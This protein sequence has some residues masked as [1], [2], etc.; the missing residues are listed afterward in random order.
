LGE[1]TNRTE[2]P[3]K[4]K[5]EEMKTLEEIYEAMDHPKLNEGVD[6]GS[7]YFGMS[8][9]EGV[10]EALRW[11]AGDMEDGEFEYAGG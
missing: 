3:K 8:Y 10:M 6:E 11:V 7:C 4:T 5:G 2:Q 1:S 9:E